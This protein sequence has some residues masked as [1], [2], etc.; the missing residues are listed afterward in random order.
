MAEKGGHP[1]LELGTYNERTYRRRQSFFERNETP[2]VERRSEP[3]E[4]SLSGIERQNYERYLYYHIFPLI[5]TDML[6]KINYQNLKDTTTFL[7]KCH[8]QNKSLIAY[9]NKILLLQ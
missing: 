7:M 8:T 9:K 3:N 2:E 6:H 4:L 1:N 5:M